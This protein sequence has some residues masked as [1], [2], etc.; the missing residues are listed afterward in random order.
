MA[1]N[2]V[3]VFFGAKA[4]TK[5]PPGIDV[6]SITDLS[7]SMQ[8]FASFIASVATITALENALIA[9][10][11]GILS[12]NRYSFTRG[13]GDTLSEIERNVIVN[14]VSTRWAPGA[15][16]LNSTVTVPTL[17]AN[18]GNRVEDMGLATN[19]V[20]ATDRGYLSAN[21]RIIISGSDEQSLATDFNP[22]PLFSYRYVGVHSV[23]LS[24]SE[25]AGPNPVPAGTLVGFVYTTNTTGVAVYIDGNT[26][27]NR[28]DVPVA[29]VTA[30]ADDSAGYP[31][32]YTRQINVDQARLTN[33]AIYNINFFTSGFQLLAQSLGSALGRFLFETS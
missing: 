30:N 16:V 20:S 4:R 19:I 31:G 7:G 25:P 12:S 24:I 28:A 1:G 15:N 5:K 27:N 6:T 13:G 10:G 2:S 8:P 26:I 14:G 17:V 3:P 32:L 29:N 22:S 33:G 11:I 9:E 23:I 18:L 21:E